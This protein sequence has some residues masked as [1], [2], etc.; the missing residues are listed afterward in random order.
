ML[1]QQV[2][3]GFAELAATKRVRRWEAAGKRLPIDFMGTGFGGRAHRVKSSGHDLFRLFTT[4]RQVMDGRFEGVR[5]ESGERITV[6]ES[7]R[8]AEVDGAVDAAMRI[9]RHLAA[10]F[11]TPMSL[12]IPGMSWLYNSHDEATKDFALH[13]YAGLG[14]GH[15]WN[16]RSATVVPGLTA[17]VTE[18]IIRTHIAAETYGS[19]SADEVQLRRKR[20]ELLL[21]AHTL[22]GALGTGK[23]VAQLLAVRNDR[24]AFHPAAIR[25]IQVPSLLRASK[26]ALDVVDQARQTGRY[27]A[28]NWDELV[29]ATALGQDLELSAQL[30]CL[31][32]QALAL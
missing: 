17:I 12:P 25:H 22:V 27:E 7:G 11:L 20:T 3:A 4:L 2:A 8:F 28:R 16:L 13:A 14:T 32:A 24:G 10:D 1:D 9:M 23:A 19:S 31:A 18:V 5:W 30:E 6:Q 15:G 21:A 26:L 29:V